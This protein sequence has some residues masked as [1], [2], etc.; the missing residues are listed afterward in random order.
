M[1]TAAYCVKIETFRKKF[2]S[3]TSEEEE[4]CGWW[5]QHRD[6]VV[7]CTGARWCDVHTL[8]TRRR[9]K[10]SFVL[11]SVRR[12]VGGEDDWCRQCLTMFLLTVCLARCV[13]QHGEV[14]RSGSVQLQHADPVGPRE[15]FVHRS[16]GDA[17]RSGPQRYQQAA[18]ATGNKTP[19]H[20]FIYSLNRNRWN[21]YHSHNTLCTHQYFTYNY[22]TI[23]QFNIRGINGEWSISS[24][25][26]SAPE[27]NKFQIQWIQLTDWPHWNLFWHIFWIQVHLK[28]HKKIL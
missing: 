14:Q 1:N 21:K 25:L 13:G 17:V 22:M 6:E 28:R 26:L 27:K 24:T 20:N 3:R 12:A 7:E 19:L 10:C 18:A 2:T 23:C 4:R 11:S 8:L 5:E 9:V 16:A 15:G